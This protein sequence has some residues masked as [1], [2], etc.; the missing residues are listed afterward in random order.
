MVA[1]DRVVGKRCRVRE[2][3][4]ADIGWRVVKH[5]CDVDHNL[6]TGRD[7]DAVDGIFNDEIRDR[8]RVDRSPGARARDFRDIDELQIGGGRG[9]VVDDAHVVK[10]RRV[11]YGRHRDQVTELLPD[12]GS[13]LCIGFLQA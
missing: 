9:Q 3:K 13:G 7:V 11:R 12:G 6:F 10:R 5:H 2:R 8:A 1:F 4:P